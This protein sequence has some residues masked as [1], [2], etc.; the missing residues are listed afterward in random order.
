MKP[1]IARVL[2]STDLQFRQQS[3]S[4]LTASKLIKLLLKL[5]KF[6]SLTAEDCS[7][8]VVLLVM[9]VEILVLVGLILSGCIKICF[10]F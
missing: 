5:E 10:F 3:F 9:T 4:E 7:N 2:L 1:E 6:A 8:F